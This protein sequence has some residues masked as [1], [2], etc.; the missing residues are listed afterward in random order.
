MTLLKQ[1]DGKIQIARKSTNTWNGEWEFV[2][3]IVVG[4]D[5]K[6]TWFM[7]M[8]GKEFDIKNQWK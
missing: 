7:E 2:A 4:M 8:I 3:G 6:I 1:G 5:D